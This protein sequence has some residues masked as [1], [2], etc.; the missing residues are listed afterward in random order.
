MDRANGASA[1]VPRTARGPPSLRP[2]MVCGPRLLKEVEHQR[3]PCAQRKLTTRPLGAYSEPW[4]PQHLQCEGPWAP[5]RLKHELTT[6]AP[7]P[8]SAY[9]VRPLGA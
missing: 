6:R 1:P 5:P 2:C 4:A 7:G 3:P 8:C 9:N